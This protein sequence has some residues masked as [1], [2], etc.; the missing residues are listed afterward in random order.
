[1]SVKRLYE[2]YKDVMLYLIFGV[3]TTAVNVIVY[4]LAAHPLGLGTMPSTIIAWMLAVAFA[5]ITNRK[6]VFHSSVSSVKETL[7]EMGSFFACRLATGGVD[8]VC[9]LV[10][11]DL[12]GLNDVIVKFAANIIVIVLNYVASKLVIFRPKGK[13]KEVVGE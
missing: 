5:Y 8:W 6:W 1:M 2:Q 3:C 9:M 11:V 10:F 4:W 7:A 12:I 13:I